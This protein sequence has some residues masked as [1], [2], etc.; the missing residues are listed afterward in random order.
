MTGRGPD[1]FHNLGERVLNEH[2]EVFTMLESEVQAFMDEQ[3]KYARF[4]KSRNENAKA[5]SRAA[6]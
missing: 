6:E 2:L 1:I 3:N 5:K 4:L